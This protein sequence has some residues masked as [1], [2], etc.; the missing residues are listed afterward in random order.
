MTDP[1]KR[2]I[3]DQGHADEA[4]LRHLN[5]SARPRTNA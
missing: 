3:T 2:N 1:D 5:G 4:D